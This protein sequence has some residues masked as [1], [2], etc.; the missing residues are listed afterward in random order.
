MDRRWSHEAWQIITVKTTK[1]Q[2]NKNRA[3]RRY[4]SQICVSPSERQQSKQRTG[5][6][7]NKKNHKRFAKDTVVKTY[8]RNKDKN[9]AANELRATQKRETY[10]PVFKLILLINSG[11]DWK[12]H[13]SCS[14][15]AANFGRS[16]EGQG[17][18][19]RGSK[20]LNTIIQMEAGHLRENP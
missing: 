20:V 9:H 14:F 3:R 19:T 15:W 4:P 6:E 10:D 17:G 18:P 2:T 7:P 1:T 8:C 16:L 12:D 11:T 13:N 5:Q